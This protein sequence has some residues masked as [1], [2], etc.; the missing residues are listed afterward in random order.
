MVPNGVGSARPPANALFRP[1]WQTLQLP[2]R[3]SSAPRSLSS[4]SNEDASGG[5][6]SAMA[7]SQAHMTNPVPASRRTTTSARRRRVHIAAVPRYARDQ[8]KTQRSLRRGL[9][10]PALR[11]RRKG[12]GGFVGLSV[13][14][15]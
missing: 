7:G 15:R 9:K 14:L 8:G 3:A 1:A 13:Q 5:V 6:V 4:G 10:V 2:I 12:G 11:E